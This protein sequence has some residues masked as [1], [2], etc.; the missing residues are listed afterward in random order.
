MLQQPHVACYQRRSKEAH[1]LPEWKVPRHHGEHHAHWFVG[2]ECV[3]LCIVHALIPHEARPMLGIESA[4][5]RTLGRFIDGR[6]DRLPHLEGHQAA[7]P[8]LFR[9][10]QVGQAADHHGTLGYRSETPAQCR[11]RS[12]RQACIELVGRELGEYR[13]CLAG[14]GVDGRS[15]HVIG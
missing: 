6:L 4:G 7:D 5:H 10:E 11:V 15:R 13:E 12:A 8:L 3:M 14:G 2:H 9:V 1:H